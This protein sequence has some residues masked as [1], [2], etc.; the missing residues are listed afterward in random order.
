MPSLS[1]YQA[2]DAA[3]RDDALALE[4]DLAAKLQPLIEA[5][6]A[7]A[8]RNLS[9][10]SRVLV[11]A[12]GSG[13][14]PPDADELMNRAALDQ[15]LQAELA[16]IQAQAVQRVVDGIATTLGIRLD[17]RNPLMQGVLAGRGQKITHIGESLRADVMGQVNDAWE[18][19][20]SIRDT[21][22]LISEHGTEFAA[23]RAATIARTEIIGA[24]NQAS[25]AAAQLSGAAPYKQWL[26]TLDNRT[27]ES[28][29]ELNGETVPINDVFSNGLNA[30]GDPY[31]DPGEVINCRCTVIYSNDAAGNDLGGLE[32]RRSLDAIGA[33]SSVE[34]SVRAYRMVDAATAE[35]TATLDTAF[36]HIE[37]SGVRY[38]P[39]YEGEPLPRVGMADLT[40]GNGGVFQAGEI[41]I[42]AGDGVLEQQ[43]N[44]FHEY[45]HMLDYRLGISGKL[46]LG[47]KADGWKAFIKA[48]RGTPEWER[49]LGN[50]SAYII[51]P[52][53][54]WAR[55]FSQYIAERAGPEYLGQAYTRSHLSQQWSEESWSKMRPFVEAI[56]QEKGVLR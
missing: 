23:S 50:H 43:F 2:A 52:S 4:D 32:D 8:A 41:K 28:H 33:P 20:L 42:R 48:A 7:R 16:A 44:L 39:Q 12:S 5:L 47:V 24:A 13:W 53:E 26:A 14:T 34:P 49:W 10:R 46:G 29:A 3:A 15:E 21:A 30:P 38:T 11:A 18:R 17:L 35:Q 25:L 19:G 55:S 9:V 6:V 36:R 40:A 54:V 37:T 27:R 1:S 56:L 31:G 51:N 45:G 22:A